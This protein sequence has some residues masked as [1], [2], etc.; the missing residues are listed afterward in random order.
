MKEPP[1]SRSNDYF[2][3][4]DVDI[5]AEPVS[6]WVLNID[7]ISPK[8]SVTLVVTVYVSAQGDLD[9][10]EVQNS[11]INE[12]ETAK[13]VSRL[14]TTLFIP[15]QRAGLPVPSSRQIEITIAQATKP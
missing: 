13:L 8:Q 12:L 10:F 9:H 14:E 15:A 11:S 5:R 3:S 1:L 4:Q 2:E 6:D 7:A